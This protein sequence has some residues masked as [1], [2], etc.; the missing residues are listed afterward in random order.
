MNAVLLAI[1]QEP[2]G[3]HPELQPLYTVAATAAHVVLLSGMATA[4]TQAASLA[5]SS[6]APIARSISSRRLSEL[7]EGHTPVSPDEAAGLLRTAL[8]DIRQ[9]RAPLQHQLAAMGGGLLTVQQLEH[10]LLFQLAM[11]HTWAATPD[12]A[13]CGGRID[14]QHAA[15]GRAAF[16]AALELSHDDFCTSGLLVALSNLLRR[17]GAEAEA[18]AALRRAVAAA[19]ACGDAMQELNAA[20]TL[21][22]A[23]AAQDS[24]S[25]QEMEGLVA[26]MQR[27]LK[28]CKPWSPNPI[29]SHYRE[30]RS[31]RAAMPGLG[32]NFV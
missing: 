1:L 12:G 28:D 32:L 24:W 15:A 27:C 26:A 11:V 3:H 10:N 18:E 9:L 4:H 16:S 30:V 14:R 19:R 6:A 17:T 21:A 8:D 2:S 20:A 23:I 25:Y 7:V 31:S 22:S 5:N 29:Q 13:Y